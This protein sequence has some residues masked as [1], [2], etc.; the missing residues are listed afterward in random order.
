MPGAVIGGSVVGFRELVTY[1][2]PGD[3]VSGADA[4]WGLRAFSAA[5][6][7]DTAIRLRRDG[8]SP[9][10]QDFVTISGGGLDLTSISSFKGSDNLFVVTLY[11]QTGNAKTLTQ[12]TA[13]NQP[14]FTLAGLGSNPIMTFSNASSTRLVGSAVNGTQP[15]TVSMLLNSDAVGAL[16]SAWGTNSQAMGSDQSGTNNVW[17]FAGGTVTT[18]TAADATWHA[19]QAVFNGASSDLNVDGSSNT[20]N[21]G[22]NDPGGNFENL[23]DN[24]GLGQNFSGKINEA[25]RWFI[26][27]SGTQSTN[28]EANQQT[29][30]GY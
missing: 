16:R 4:W 21:P 26:A 17:M 8:A 13:A 29:F 7:G 30:W 15:N 23:G 11:D 3:I 2:G 20:V 24:S 12:S 19:V 6:V 1:T 25:G 18:V 14:T 22:T 9:A 27:F 28:M 5:T 10:E